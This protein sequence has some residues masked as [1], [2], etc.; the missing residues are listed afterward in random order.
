M[1]QKWSA[2]SSEGKILKR[3]SRAID[4]KTK[5]DSLDKMDLEELLSLGKQM[6]YISVQKSNLAKNSDWEDRITA[7]EKARRYVEEKQAEIEMKARQAGK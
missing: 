3:I 1:P 7:L 6:A 2:S 4:R 5:P